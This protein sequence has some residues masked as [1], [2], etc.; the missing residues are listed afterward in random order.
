[1]EETAIT[2]CPKCSRKKFV[3]SQ[4]GAIQV[5]CPNCR[6]KWIW[7]TDTQTE[8]NGGN[9]H[10]TDDELP[11]RLTVAG[12]AVAIPCYA[13]MIGLF[14]GIMY[15]LGPPRYASVMLL[16]LFISVLFCFSL[17]HCGRWFLK[18]ELNIAVTKKLIDNNNCYAK[19]LIKIVFYLA[20]TLVP[21]AIYIYMFFANQWQVQNENKAKNEANNK[22]I[23]DQIN[24]LTQKLRRNQGQN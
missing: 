22:A 14:N 5:T 2:T 13:A 15:V 24:D 3:P 19:N 10:D 18:K 1:M 4:S 7:P 20:F 9:D 23:F 17:F 11:Y 16:V 12:W 8:V 21:C 6:T